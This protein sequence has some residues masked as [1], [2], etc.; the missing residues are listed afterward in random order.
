MIS[1][2]APGTKAK[3]ITAGGT[4][5]I[6]S[7]EACEASSMV[8]CCSNLNGVNMCDQK[9]DRKVRLRSEVRSKDFVEICD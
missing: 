3:G 1:D 8:N 5:A 4:A 7:W 2:P 9:S 6:E